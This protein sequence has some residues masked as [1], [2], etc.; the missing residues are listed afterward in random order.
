MSNLLRLLQLNLSEN[1]KIVC[2][3]HSTHLEYSIRHNF[4]IKR[5]DTL[6]LI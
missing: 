4:P 1:E 6:G 3:T 5:A 2:C